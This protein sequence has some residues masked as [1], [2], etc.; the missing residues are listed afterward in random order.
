M[1][2]K[3]GFVCLSVSVRDDITTIHILKVMDN[4][5]NELS[6]EKNFVA[7]NCKTFIVNN[8]VEMQWSKPGPARF[9]RWDDVN[10]WVQVK[11]T[12][13]EKGSIHGF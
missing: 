1:L 5:S 6:A 12:A 4:K 13:K 10:G 3:A 8:Y 2:T 7:N 9:M 11:D